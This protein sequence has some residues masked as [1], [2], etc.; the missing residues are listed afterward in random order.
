MNS[1]QAARCGEQ[2]THLDE[3]HGL[4]DRQRVVHGQ[5]EGELGVELRLSTVALCR[6]DLHEELRDVLELELVGRHADCAGGLVKRACFHR[7][8]ATTY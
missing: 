7:S 6:G 1:R 3:D 8:K 4:A 2:P 5:E